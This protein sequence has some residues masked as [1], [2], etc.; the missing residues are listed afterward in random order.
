MLSHY[1]S[2]INM[3]SNIS[4]LPSKKR[5]SNHLYLLK[6]CRKHSLILLSSDKK[7][8]TLNKGLSTSCC[9]N[10]EGT[11][12]YHLPVCHK[13]LDAVKAELYML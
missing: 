3:G 12:Y 13:V 7:K 11:E 1:K 4:Y 2:M 6:A 10:F 8:L 9:V 5:Q